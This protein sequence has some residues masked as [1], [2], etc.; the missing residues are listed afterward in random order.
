VPRRAQIRADLDRLARL[1]PDRLQPEL[2]RGGLAADGDEQL[3]TSTPCSRS[4]ASTSA[5][6]NGSSRTRIR[7][8]PS[9]S[10]TRTPSVDHA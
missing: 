5:D 6:A 10:A 7:G 3:R 4:D 9:S 8:A 1:E 2:L